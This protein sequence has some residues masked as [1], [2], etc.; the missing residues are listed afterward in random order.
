MAG[1][2]K[3][4][5]TGVIGNVPKSIRHCSFGS[6][7][8]SMA[9]KHATQLTVKQQGSTVSPEVNSWRWKQQEP[10]F[11][12]SRQKSLFV[13]IQRQNVCLVQNDYSRRGW[14]L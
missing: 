6:Y 14:N 9:I 13:Q 11:A 2:I 3:K 4:R 8:K 10:E 7:I 5:S 1:H 12:N